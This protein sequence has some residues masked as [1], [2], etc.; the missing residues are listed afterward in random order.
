[1]GSRTGSWAPAGRAAA[2]SAITT[3]SRSA[4]GTRARCAA[5]AVGAQWPKAYASGAPIR[6]E[7]CVILEATPHPGANVRHLTPRFAG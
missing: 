1:M 6:R 3:P 4:L 5:R 2:S 7:S